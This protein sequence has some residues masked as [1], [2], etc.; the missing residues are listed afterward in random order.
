[1][2]WVERVQLIV[3]TASIVVLV[4]IVA[5]WIVHATAWTSPW[6]PDAPPPVEVAPYKVHPRGIDPYYVDDYYFEGG[7]VVL[8][9]YWKDENTYKDE[10][11][12]LN[13]DNVTI[14]DRRL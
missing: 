6:E 3:A 9:G 4:C 11:R 8:D 13:A 12:V 7:A 14:R 10:L 1:M 2:D 5:F